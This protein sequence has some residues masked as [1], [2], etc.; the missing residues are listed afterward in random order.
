MHPFL[1]CNVAFLT[2]RLFGISQISYLGTEHVDTSIVSD[3]VA[4][5]TLFIQDNKAEDKKIASIKTASEQTSKGLPQAFAS[6]QPLRE[7]VVPESLEPSCLRACG[8]RGTQ[9]LPLGTSTV[10][11]KTCVIGARYGGFLCG[12]GN[13]EKFGSMCRLCYT[14]VNEALRVER[15]LQAGSIDGS[16]TN[17]HV[18]M[19]ETMQPPE[20]EDCTDE[21]ARSEEAVRKRLI[22]VLSI[23]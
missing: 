3:A 13:L 20:L 14:D 12:A 16:E 7:T 15:D 8:D 22:C 1:R 19:C 21:C 17:K 9:G 10:C 4:G 2:R 11:D 6:H 5:H 18:V 23:I